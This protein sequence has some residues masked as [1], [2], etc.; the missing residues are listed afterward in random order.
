MDPEIAA[1]DA[2]IARMEAFLRRAKNGIIEARAKDVE[3]GKGTHVPG[4][5]GAEA[6]GGARDVA[7]TGAGL[8]PIV[9]G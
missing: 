6:R 7:G 8:A 1:M 2:E 4:L 3:Q 5:P 9:P